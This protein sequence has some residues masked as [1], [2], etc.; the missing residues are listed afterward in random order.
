MHRQY[1][2][3]FSPNLNREMELLI[4]GH[5]GTRVLVFPTRR[6]RFFDYENFGMVGALEDVLR[7]GGLQLYCVDSVDAES[8]YNTHCHPR[9]RICR[10]IQYEQYIL[11]E[12]LPLS[13]RINPHSYL[14]AHGCSMG[15]FHAVNL[16]F[17]HP[18]LFVK[19]VGLSGRY[20]LTRPT[21]EFRD[22]FDGHYDNDVYFHTPNH[23]LPKLADESILGWIRRMHI[24]L[25]TGVH[26]PFLESNQNLSAALW[27]KQIAN[28]LHVWD[29][30]AHQA[31]YWQQMVRY[32]L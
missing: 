23:F 17:R 11:R 18:Q 19:V 8:L 6:G 14:I 26:D 29:G 13:E 16:A 12:V 9:Q 2:K 20:D 30:R 15:A 1:H 21:A 22:L 5:G 7:S 27:S 25:V 31:L 28:T 4:F 10:H 24:V 3:W 32:Y